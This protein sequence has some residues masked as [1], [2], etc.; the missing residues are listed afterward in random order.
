MSFQ[1]TLLRLLVEGRTVAALAQRHVGSFFFFTCICFT[2]PVQWPHLVFCKLAIV[3]GYGQ[4][5]MNR[6]L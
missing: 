5:G 6:T 1:A 3:L 4:F 2:F